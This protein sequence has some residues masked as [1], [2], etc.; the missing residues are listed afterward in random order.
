[1]LIRT[2]IQTY[3]LIVQVVPWGFRKLLQWIKK[4][5]N[6]PPVFVTENG[7][8]DLAEFNDTLR[9]HYYTVGIFASTQLVQ[10]C[11]TVRN[12]AVHTSAVAILYY[13]ILDVG[14]IV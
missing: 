2:V 14:R 9:I 12:M 7:V 11:C 13:I 6:N 10:D 4:E 1:M 5:Y 3:D 8:A